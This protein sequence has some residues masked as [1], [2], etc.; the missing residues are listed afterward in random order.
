MNSHT[1]NHT[2]QLVRVLGITLFCFISISH[3][4]PQTGTVA[5]E[6]NRLIISNDNLLISIW[7]SEKNSLKIRANKLKEAPH[8]SAFFIRKTVDATPIKKYG[9]QN[10]WKIGTYTVETSKAGFTVSQ[11]GK[12]L[13]SSR[14]SIA[15]DYLTEEKNCFDKELFYG[16]GQGSDRFALYRCRFSLFQEARYGDRACLYIPFF[17]T[18]GGDAFYYDANSRDTVKFKNKHSAL[19]QYSTKKNV[20]QYYYYHEPKPKTLVSR[21]YT[22]SGSHAMI[23]KWAFG[24]IQSK[25]GYQNQQEVIDVINTFKK[26]KIPISAIILDLQ[27]F[28][29]MGDLAYDKSNWPDPLKMDRFLEDN[30]VKLL[31]ISEPF[32]TV[33]SKNFSQ[34]DKHGLLAKDKD[35]K[36]ITWKD[37][38]CF[39]ASPKGSIVNPLAPNAAEM[40]GAKYIHMMEQ[41]IDAFWTDLGEPE[42]VPSGAFFN[43]FPEREFHNYYNK[44][45][46]RLIYNAISKKFPDRRLL[47]LSRSGW[48]G[49]ARYGVSVWSGDCTSSFD[50]LALQTV[51]GINSGL[52]GFSYWGSDVGG[53]ESR[54]MKPE[55]E[56]FIRWMQFGTFSPV[57]R[58]HG[59]K[60]PRE[61]WIHGQDALKIIKSFIQTRYRLLP[62]IYSTAYQTYSK[63]IP[64]MR[65]MLFEHPRDT[66]PEV[67]EYAN[68]YYFGDFILAAPVTASLSESPTQD[69]YLPGKLPWYDFYTYE[70]AEPGDK[71]AKLSL[72][73]MPVYIAEGAIIPTMEN[74]KSVLLLFP[75]KKKTAF[76]VYD[77]DGVTNNFKKGKFMAINIQMDINGVT[78]S[79]VKK[80]KEVLLKIPTTVKHFKLSKLTPGKTARKENN[81]YIIP[82]KLKPGTTRVEF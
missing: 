49:S 78:F 42:N 77:D 41:G 7:S 76:T 27:W 21:F 6:K 40:L 75:S 68:Q 52:T 47:I 57:F 44:E 43:Q 59:A 74:K 35:G 58:P 80:S 79:N 73:R 4:F 67:I 46:S 22:F 25:Y 14:F 32:Y 71:T 2:N 36:T 50:G 70:P 29:Q 33:D 20:I 45:W 26:Y 24:Y 37:W 3:L 12:K 16:I 10:Q 31:T 69:I 13:F 15:G 81:A 66:H 1:K 34:F 23:P 60:S 8:L 65:P 48:T 30:G 63:G 82:I 53:F 38:W 72:H 56:L 54:G 17:F 28:K 51:L 64:M 19:A 61:P 9:S 5:V 11:N 18:G 55:K 62:Y 39:D